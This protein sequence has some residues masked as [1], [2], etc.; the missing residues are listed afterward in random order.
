MEQLNSSKPL[1]PASVQLL[2]SNEKL[3]LMKMLC[4]I[5]SINE[6]SSKQ[7]KVE[8]LVFY[9]SLVDFDMLNIFDMK[10]KDKYIY[11]S[12]LN[13]YFR[14]QLKVNKMLLTMSNMK[15]VE[16]NGD[17]FTK[18]EN[19]KV[20]LLPFGRKFFEEN[21]SEYFKYLYDEYTEAFGKVA[22]SYENIKKMKEGPQ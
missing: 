17:K 19:L 22:Y 12:S 20:K 9:Y 1:I 16:I 18:K 7:R 14:F 15:F 13:R 6:K 11:T 21:K 3:E 5:N 2:F 4:L 10:T 8:E